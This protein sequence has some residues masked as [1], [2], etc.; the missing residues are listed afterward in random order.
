M[1]KKY[2]MVIKEVE[3]QI[4]IVEAHKASIHKFFDDA[5]KEF[6]ENVSAFIQEMKDYRTTLSET[7]KI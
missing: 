6:D 1:I 3:G 5:K 2:G 7:L 4:G